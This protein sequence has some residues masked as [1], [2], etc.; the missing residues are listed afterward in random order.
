MKERLPKVE[1][2]TI[3]VEAASLAEAE[4]IAFVEAKRQKPSAGFYSLSA[5]QEGD[6]R[7]CVVVMCARIH[8][9]GAQ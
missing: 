7:Y 6:G 1:Q 2:L 8:T 9:F 5:T 4:R 3:F